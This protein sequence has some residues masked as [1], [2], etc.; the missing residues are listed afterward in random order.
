MHTVDQQKHYIREW[1]P[2]YRTTSV[3]IDYNRRK[4]SLEIIGHSS[5]RT[6]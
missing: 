3:Y 1:T 4:A 5:G 6:I 2:I